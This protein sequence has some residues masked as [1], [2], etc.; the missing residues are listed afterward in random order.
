MARKIRERLALGDFNMTEDAAEKMPFDTYC[1][2]RLE[3]YVRNNTK[4]ATVGQL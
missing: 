2:N 3:S 1:K 4:D